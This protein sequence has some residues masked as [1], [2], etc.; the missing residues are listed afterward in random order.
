MS[1]PSK[2]NGV[3]WEANSTQPSTERFPLSR[4]VGNRFWK[5][6]HT[7]VMILNEITAKDDFSFYQTDLPN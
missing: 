1:R 2:G 5:V 7:F 6:V 3:R 4:R